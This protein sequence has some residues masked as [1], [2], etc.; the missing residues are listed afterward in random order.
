[1]EKFAKLLELEGIGQVLAVLDDSEED[2]M[3]ACLK[4]SFQGGQGLGVCSVKL[5]F[6]EG[7]DG[8]AS[9][10]AALENFD[11]ETARRMVEPVIKQFGDTFGGRFAS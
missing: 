4:I 6:K 5:N 7:D 8:Y 1:M 9:A 3:G 11:E 10:E 2:G